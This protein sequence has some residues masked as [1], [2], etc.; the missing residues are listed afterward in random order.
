MDFAG[1]IF[2]EKFDE[3]SIITEELLSPEE[4]LSGNES[5]HDLPTE[6]DSDALSFGSYGSVAEYINAQSRVWFDKETACNSAD[7]LISLGERLK[8]A[9]LLQ[10]LLLTFRSSEFTFSEAVA[11]IG[12]WTGTGTEASPERGR[13]IS[14]KLAQSCFRSTPQI[15][16]RRIVALSPNES[17]A[18]DA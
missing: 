10:M 17:P 15:G 11:M 18:L 13:S 9:G 16:I 6:A 12:E 14:R 7:D 5:E 1:K 3:T 4:F 2:G 8:K